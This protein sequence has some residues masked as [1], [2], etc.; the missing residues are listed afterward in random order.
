MTGRIDFDASVEAGKCCFCGKPLVNVSG[1][2]E[3]QRLTVE[4]T[5]G[6]AVVLH[7]HEACFQ[8]WLGNRGTHRTGISLAEGAVPTVVMSHDDRL[9]NL[10]TPACAPAWSKKAKFCAPK[11]WALCFNF[12]F[13]G[14]LWAALVK[15]SRSTTVQADVAC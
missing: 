7:Y 5:D 8:E 15:S 11:L 9:Q 13:Y 2:T 14:T 3:K 1:K 6:K 4:T 12:E 10:W